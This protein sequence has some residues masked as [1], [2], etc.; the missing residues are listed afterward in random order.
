MNSYHYIF[1]E[2]GIPMKSLKTVTATLAVLFFVICSHASAAESPNRA[3]LEEMGC[4]K[5]LIVNADDLGRSPHSNAAILRGFREGILT[6]TSLMT[7]ALAA[8][9]AY[10]LVRDNPDLDVGVHLVLAR[11]DAPGNLYGPVSPLE[12]VASLVDPDGNFFTDM[13]YVLREG[14]KKEVLG[15]LHAQLRAALDNG[16]DVTHLD[17]HKGFYHT[18]DPKSLKATLMIAQRYDLPIRWVGSAADPTLKKHGIVV[19]DYI[20]GFDMATEHETKKERL[21]EILANLKEGI[22]ELFVHPASGGFTESEAAARGS[23]LALVLD[24]D[25]RNAIEDNG[26]CLIG[27]RELRDFQ[28]KMNKE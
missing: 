24:P 16:V 14:D 1:N 21:L 23:E 4:Q 19:T 18:Y 26:I 17:C 7:P 3:L 13:D 12:K 2:R 20:T 8:R 11:D 22:T 9:E 10:D 5:A 25:I 27:Y 15:E 6:S 28:R